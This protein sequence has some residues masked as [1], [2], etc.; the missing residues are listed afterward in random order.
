MAWEQIVP[1]IVYEFRC[2]GADTADLEVLATVLA[3]RAPGSGYDEMK[4]LLLGFSK[5]AM[6]DK[7]ASVP[8]L[9]AWSVAF[10]ADE[11]PVTMIQAFATMR[12]WDDTG[13]A[14][15]WLFHAAGVTAAEASAMASPDLDHLRGIAALRGY[16]LPSP[17]GAGTT[18]IDWDEV[19]RLLGRTNES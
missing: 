2:A 12:E 19:H 11:V 3:Q 14:H 4:Y 16:R 9:L 18:G 8:D 17:H 1:R 13:V 10:V 7:A 6:N 5:R 15:G